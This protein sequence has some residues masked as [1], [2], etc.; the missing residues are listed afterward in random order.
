[1]IT[2]T[3]VRILSY[4]KTN[5]QARVKD[6]VDHLGIGNV[7]VHRQVKS[8]LDDNKITKF[9]TP[10][11]VFYTLAKMSEEEIT[12]K[13]TKSDKFLNKYFAYVDPTGQFY[14][15]IQGFRTWLRSVNKSN[16]EISLLSRY[17]QDREDINVF[18][19]KDG[20]VDATHNISQIFKENMS[21]DAVYYMDFYSLPTFGK[22]RLGSLMLYSK[23]SENRDLI[24]QVADE[25]KPVIRNLIEKA[26][27]DAIGFLPHSILRKV[28][29]L[30]E[31]SKRLNL[32][33]PK[34]DLIKAYSGKIRVAQKTLGKLEERIQNAKE[35]IFINNNG[36]TYDK[37]L[38][39]D[40]A[41][42]SAST[43]N[44]T[45]KK[46]KSMG[47]AKQVY[48]FAIVGSLKGFEV[49]REV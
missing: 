49:I 33:L 44:E 17:M 2:D 28:Q 8:L 45:A 5:G 10:P 25:A 11:Q 37:V 6:L 21:L 27:I 12:V 46:L 31:F 40:D 26:G 24:W 35:T 34:V 13:D 23:Q 22:T 41:V 36:E 42:G 20:L 16:Q 38:L 29:F 43:L 14:T 18:F 9:G 32:S 4:I 47:I 3:K 48:G 7:A 30:K 19:N 1:M 39:I 15:G